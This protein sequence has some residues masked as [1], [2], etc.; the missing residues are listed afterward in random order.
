[1]LK[2]VAPLKFHDEDDFMTEFG[3]MVTGAQVARLQA[4]M[5][6]YILRR[7]KEDVEKSIPPKEETIID[8]ELTTLQKKYYRAIFEKNRA[9]VPRLTV[10]LE[11]DLI[12]LTLVR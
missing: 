5:S 6:P 11:I 12:Y 2:F 7:H 3:H 8:V 10:P 1:M 4:M 9:Y